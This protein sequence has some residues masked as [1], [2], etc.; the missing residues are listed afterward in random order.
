MKRR[1]ARWGMF[2]GLLVGLGASWWVWRETSAP[3][4]AVPIPDLD[5]VHPNVADAIRYSAAEVRR[6]PHSAAAWGDYGTL[7]LAHNCRPEAVVCFERAQEFDPR[8]FRW[9]YYLGYIHE[10]VDLQAA[11]KDYRSALERDPHYLSARIRLARVLMRLN[12]FGEAKQQLDAA[13]E[14]MPQSPYVLLEQG[15][16]AA[17]QGEYQQARQFLEAAVSASG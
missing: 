2:L 10:V 3:V 15:R 8:E 4:T 13:A 17:A 12:R 11:V 1:L 14:F 16:F 7:L 9:P 5:Q 6:R